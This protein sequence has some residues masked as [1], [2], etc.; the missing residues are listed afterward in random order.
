MVDGSG[1]GAHVNSILH[2]LSLLT[3]PTLHQGWKVGGQDGL[4]DGEWT[5][6]PQSLT[7]GVSGGQDTHPSR[8]GK[9]VF[10]L[11][12]LDEEDNADLCEPINAIAQQRL[13]SFKRATA[14]V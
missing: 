9:V 1:D 13:V 4:S 12:G 7:I 3:F 10:Q 11:G 8:L 2:S 14:F 6:D 5:L